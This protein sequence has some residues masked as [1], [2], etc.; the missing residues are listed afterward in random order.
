VTHP[1]TQKKRCISAVKAR[2]PKH[3]LMKSLRLV[4]DLEGIPAKTLE[5]WHYKH[6]KQLRQEAEAKAVQKSSKPVAGQVADI[7]EK[8]GHP[9]PLVSPSPP[10]PEVKPYLDIES[11]Q[12]RCSRCRSTTHIEYRMETYHCTICGILEFE[13]WPEEKTTEYFEHGPD[14]WML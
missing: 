5:D 9:F 6:Q 2:L 14:S 7:S 11:G 1:V 10:P 13:G 3:G 4:S 8:A 12:L